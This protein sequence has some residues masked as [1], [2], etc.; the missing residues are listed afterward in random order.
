MPHP[1]GDLKS[2][3]VPCSIG[4]DTACKVFSESIGNICIDS[5]SAKKYYH[6]IRGVYVGVCV[7]KEGGAAWQLVPPKHAQH[8]R[9]G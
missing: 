5:S 9:P 6:F 2:A 4:F 7:W 1:A 3:D 8:G